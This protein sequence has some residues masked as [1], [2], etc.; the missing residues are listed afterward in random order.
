VVFYIAHLATNS[1]I[2]FLLAAMASGSALYPR[3]ASNPTLPAG[4]GPKCTNAAGQNPSNLAGSNSKTQFA[5]GC[6]LSDGDCATGCC[7]KKTGIC[8]N[9]GVAVSA[10]V[11]GCGGVFGTGASSPAGVAAP[12]G[13]A[14]AART[15][16]NRSGPKCTDATGQNLAAAGKAAGTQ[17]ITGCCDSDADC[18]SECCGK[19]TG[20]CQALAVANTAAVGGCGGVFSSKRMFA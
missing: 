20:V 17:F 11:G 2:A 8:Q 5:T 4:A 15:L 9:L 6:C 13:A 12:S 1:H 14:V 10:A 3:Q 18:A 16:A 19:N 7:G